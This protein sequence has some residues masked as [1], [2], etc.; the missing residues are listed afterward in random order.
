M[1]DIFGEFSSLD[2]LWESEEGPP[3]VQMTYISQDVIATN[4][5]L[6]SP[7]PCRLIL[8]QKMGRQYGNSG[9]S[10]DKTIEI[11]EIKAYGMKGEMKNWNIGFG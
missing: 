2:L 3:R 10:E 7:R 4:F 11:V 5:T 9:T 1:D 6:D 8:L